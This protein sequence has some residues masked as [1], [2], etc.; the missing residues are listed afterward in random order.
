MYLLCKLY[1]TPKYIVRQSA[2][3]FNVIGSVRIYHL[4]LNA[5]IYA[6]RFLVVVDLITLSVSGRCC[7]QLEPYN[8]KKLSS[9]SFLLFC[10][11][12]S[13]FGIGNTFLY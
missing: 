3:Y 11:R 1:E 13:H 8:K 2:K 9:L 5:H 12:F 7:R 4:T 10:H 6:S